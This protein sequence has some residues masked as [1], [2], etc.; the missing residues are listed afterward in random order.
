ARAIARWLVLSAD[1]DTPP[2]D[3]PALATRLAE[4][5]SRA[6]EAGRDLQT[7]LVGTRWS[8]IDSHVPSLY[9]AVPR[10]RSFDAAVDRWLLNPIIGPLAFM[11]VMSLVFAAL[12]SWSDPAI[13]FIETV[14]GEIGGA[15]ARGFDALIAAA[16]AIATPLEITRDALV[17]GVIGG[18]GSVVVF[19]PQ[20]ALLFTFLALLEDSGYLARAAHLMDR[21]LR[22]A[23]LPGQA[24]VPLLS[25]YACA[26]PGILGTRSLPRFRD[27]LLTMSVLPLT[28]CS[29]RLPV[30]TLVIGA[31]FPPTLVL[32]GFDLPMRPLALIGMYLFS[33]VVTLIAAIVLGKFLL[34]AESSATILELP[35]YR[36][37]HLRTV[38]RMVALRCRE[39]LREAGGII[40]VATMILWALLYFPRYGAEDVLPPEVLAAHADDPDTLDALAE[41]L[42]TE[43]SF[44]GRFGHALE[45]VLSPLGYDWKIGI[46]LIGAFAARE[47]FVST[48]GVVYGSGGD[49]TE[50]DPGLRDQ[51]RA[52]KRADGTP[53]YT[54]LVGASLCVFF[55]LAMQCLST[56]AVLRSE[57]NSWRWPAFVVTYMTVLAYVGALVTYQGGRLLGF[58]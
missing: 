5:R 36:P 43:R 15:V 44:A 41:P 56:L 49:A 14:F 20:I 18:V 48:L 2:P 7:E 4:I 38:A 31:V 26:V 51:L 54:P 17:D 11:A 13:G 29:A 39:F 27:R 19:L 22:T 24:F 57:S 8:W 1:E 16:P 23:G 33:T 46:G 30:Y 3:D 6:G 25:G 10:Q 50:D 53:R 52:E 35:P 40:F 28:S 55:A 12:F 21:L 9:S 34:P 47:V 37:P 42:A 32:A 58:S 45:P